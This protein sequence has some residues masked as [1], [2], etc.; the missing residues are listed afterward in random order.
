MGTW[1]GI[2]KICMSWSAR[3]FIYYRKQAFVLLELNLWQILPVPWPSCYWKPYHSYITR[4][5][6]HLYLFYSFAMQLCPWS[7]CNRYLP[8]KKLGS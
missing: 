3:L 6:I 1:E 5:I 2:P 7:R 4:S 8:D